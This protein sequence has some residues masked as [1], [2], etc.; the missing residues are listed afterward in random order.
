MPEKTAPL[1]DKSALIEQAKAALSGQAI[2]PRP[3]L[4]LAKSLKSWDE[5]GYARKL[6]DRVRKLQDAEWTPAERLL[7]AQNHALATYKDPD[8]PAD[9]KFKRAIAI[10]QEEEDLKTTTN[11]ETLGL[12]GAIYKRMW[13]VE[14]NRLFLER[15]LGYYQRH[16]EAGIVADSTQNPGY[17]AINAAYV[18]DL[19][20]SLE[21][22]AG[23]DVQWQTEGVT[24]RRKR[25][26]ELRRRIIDVLTA[27][28]LND[29]P[30]AQDWWL[31][32]TLAQAHFGLGEYDKAGEWL[33]RAL[34]IGGIPEWRY[35]STVE[36]LARLA[37]LR[38][39]SLDTPEQAQ[40]ARRAQ[41]EFL[42]GIGIR[43]T[44]AAV[45]SAYTG[46]VGLALS[47]G[48]FRASLYHIG[49]L[50]KLA[51]IGVLNRVEALS[52]VSGGSIIG[53][54]Y[55]LELRQ[56]FREKIDDKEFSSE[57]YRQII[58]NLE[59]EFL[60]GVQRN[61]RTRVISSLV[62]NVRM[63]FSAD[64]SRTMRVGELYEKHLYARVQ[65][66]EG[67]RKRWLD[68]LK[69]V[70][71]DEDKASFKPLRDNWRRSNKVP[72]LILN[73]TSLNTGHVW[74]FTASY[75]GE[76]PA[77]INNEIDAGYRLRRMWY[78]DAPPAY[79]D[80]EGAP[81]RMRLGYAVASSSCV[82]GMFEPLSLP[83]LYKDKTVQL[84]DGGVFD[85]QGTASLLEQS[86]SV[87]L[88][89]D[90]S[91]QMTTEDKPSKSLLNVVLRSSSISQERIRWAQHR[92]LEA[93]RR[94]GLLRGLM[95]IHLKKDLDTNPADW[96]DCPDPYDSTAD[97]RPPE[98]RGP[99]TRYGVR[100]DIQQLLS[101][102]RTDLDSFSE[103]EA[104][105]LMASG[106]FMTE[107][108]FARSIKV[109][110]DVTD[111]DIRRRSR[112][113]FLDYEKSLKQPGRDERLKQL[114]EASPESAFKI[115]RLSRPLK[116]MRSLATMVALAAL[117][118]ALL[119]V[120]KN[121]H[122]LPP[123][124]WSRKLI[125]LTWGEATG[126]YTLR[127]GWVATTVLT[128]LVGGFFGSKVMK[129]AS[130]KE[131]LLRAAIGF[132]SGTIGALLAG[133][134]LLIFDKWYLHWGKTH[135]LIEREP[136]ERQ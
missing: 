3:L 76:P 54:H 7:L 41:E 103:G 59:R 94:S 67:H 28:A 84:V 47:G 108:E 90:A 85:N 19:L 32:V 126:P 69:I 72:I 45:D 58:K 98:L 100:K 48:G 106:Y 136:E 8:L 110:P 38:Q 56:L 65:D 35:Q 80:A 77:A 15:S 70:P 96:I 88:V 131:T 63:I 29:Q 115:W 33:K 125:S 36:Q 129:V 4:T 118:A 46:K 81:R 82:P 16:C 74:Q 102:V 11:Q 26:E 30:F 105:A 68:E 17:T 24:A 37:Q 73:A 135:R 79:R 27:P 95:F 78:R 40:S 55:Y 89:S 49:V 113:L 62:S 31:Q 18:L 133:I 51:D 14:G 9:Q 43:N 93:R 13:D 34:A 127:L 10:L 60:A 75:M 1:P 6:F 22:G 12:A 5:F 97:A 66:R 116:T 71:N 52:C 134:H 111:A 101:G 53:A 99:L 50:A 132:G 44:Q 107:Y 64:Y 20:A 121:P 117:A 109:F 23:T 91:G 25:A 83:D 92:E 119:W 104:Y 42:Q 123:D 39:R 112:W 130:W 86:C 120:I 87:L 124:L 2:E 114:L 21:E 61:I 128:L 122:S 57:D